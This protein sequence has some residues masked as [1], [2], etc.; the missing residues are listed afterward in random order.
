[1]QSWQTRLI[2]ERDELQTRLGRLQD[3]IS[4]PAFRALSAVDQ[5]DLR[6]QLRHMKGYREALNRRVNRIKDRPTA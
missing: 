6:E 5:T 4:S 3:F 2:H 1:M